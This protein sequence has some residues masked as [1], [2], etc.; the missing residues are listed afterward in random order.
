[1]DIPFMTLFAHQPAHR[2]TVP[3]LGSWWPGI[4]FAVLGVAAAVG[5]QA[6]VVV[7]GNRAPSVSVDL[8]VLDGLGAAPTLPQ[9]FGASRNGGAQPVAAPPAPRISAPTVHQPSTK[10]A[11]TAKRVK[12]HRVVHRKSKSRTRLAHAPAPRPPITTSSSKANLRLI[13][14]GTQTVSTTRATHDQPVIAQ[15]IRTASVT[16]TPPAPAPMPKEL[17]QAAEAPP[18]PVLPS[19]PAHEEAP[20]ALP[21]SQARDDSAPVSLMAAQPSVGQTTE[22]D[23]RAVPKPPP[24]PAPVAAT[25]APAPTPAPLQVASAPATVGPPN[26]IKFG[27]GLTDLPPS[28]QPVL[29]TVAARLIASDALRVQLVARATGGADQAMEARRISLARAVAVRAYLI[30]KGVP[31]LRMDVRALGNRADD[32]P[33][34]DQVDL[35]ILS[36]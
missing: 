9:L 13:P 7:G 10:S 30:D 17:P 34:N 24:A 20:K 23:T 25:P 14:P 33:V 8:T 4:L 28:S 36:Q 19:T 32:G 21:P 22:A 27:P 1:M 2:R 3:R 29:D 31:R 26:T 16:L 35:L 18:P 5:A 6:Q 12:A 11:R 15:P